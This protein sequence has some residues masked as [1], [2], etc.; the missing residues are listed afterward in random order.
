M[1]LR[2]LA[3][4]MLV[5]ALLPAGVRAQSD[6]APP[7]PERNPARV[8]APVVQKPLLPGEEPTVAWSETEVKAAKEKCG[9]LLAA[10]TLDYQ[11]LDPIKEGLCG[12]P[13]PI[14][15]KSI[16]SDPKVEVD[17]PATITCPLA[18]ELSAWL[19]QIVQPDAKTLLSSPVVKLHNATSYA[20]RDRYGNINEKLSEHALVNALDI[21]EFVLASGEQVTVLDSWPKDPVTPPLPLPNPARSPVTT[22]VASVSTAK[23]TGHNTSEVTKAKVA[24]SLPPAPPPVAVEPASDPKSEFVKRVHD[25]ACHTFGTVL[26]PAAN[27]AHK[28]HFHLDARERRSG[29]CQ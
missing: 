6:D 26:G 7:L 5:V 27:E 11:P 8:Q 20:C 25:D 2:H 12:A 23:P 16:G 22:S 9:Q 1:T 4:L 28:N 24:A 19:S 18:A 29:F 21:S 13:A 3:C 17:P 15:L 14:L 10:V